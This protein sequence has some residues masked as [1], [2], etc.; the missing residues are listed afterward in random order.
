VTFEMY[1][2]IVS[3]LLEPRST[4]VGTASFRNWSKDTFELDSTPSA[5]L[6]TRKKRP[7]AI[8]E[9]IFSNIL[10]CHRKAAHGCRD[11]TYDLVKERYASIPKGL[12]FR[13]V[14]W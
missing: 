14:L 7:V 8:K 4:L 2:Q 13:D 10:E 12:R 3:V 5:H 9:E 6:L 1:N 11:K